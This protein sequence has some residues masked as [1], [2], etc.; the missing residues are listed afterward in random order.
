MR[1]AHEKKWAS[2]PMAEL[3]VHVVGE[4][5]ARFLEVHQDN[6]P[7]FWR[8]ANCEN[9]QFCQA[10][11]KQHFQQDEHFSC[12]QFGATATTQRAIATVGLTVPRV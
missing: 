5:L 7:L 8:E 10:H 11:S 9:N 1:H 6:C 3:D 12:R 4:I 2:L